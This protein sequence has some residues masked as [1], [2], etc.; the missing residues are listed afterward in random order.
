MLGV[1]F[2]PRGGRVTV[3]LAL[4]GEEARIEVADQGPGIPPEDLPHLFER[5]WKSRSRGTG[6]G[7]AIVKGIVEAHGGRLSVESRLGQG[8]VFGV[9]LPR[10][11]GGR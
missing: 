2:S 1:A 4:A 10:R 9:V 11:G 5:Y 3:S 8:S 6:L 7:L